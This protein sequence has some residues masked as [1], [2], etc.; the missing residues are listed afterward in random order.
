MFTDRAH[1]EVRAGAGGNGCLSFRREAHVPKGG[2]DGGDG[3]RGGDV[4]LRCDDSLR[5]LQSFR[6]RAHFRAE[7]GGHG[8]GSQRHGADGETLV[9]AVPPGT[10]VRRWDGTRYDLVR[11]GQEVTIARGGAGGRGNT[12]FKSSVRQTPRLAERGLPGEEGR[13]DLHL[14]LLADVGLV[15]LPNA[16]KSSLLARLTRAH[17]KVAAYPFTTLEPVLGTLD[18]EDRQLVI[19]D[20]PGLIEGASEGAGLGHDF[21]AHVER[22]RLLVHVLDLA[23][24]DGSNPLENHRVIEHELAE[25]DPRLAELPRILALSKADLVPA[26][27]AEAAAVE[28]GDRLGVPAVVT[29]A[30]TGQGL[31]EL[32]RTLLRRVPVA[33]PVPEAADEDEVAEFQVFHPAAGR[34][35]EVERV[36]DGEFRVTGE[37]VDRLIARH[38]LENEEALAHVEHRLRRM[39]VI[40]ALEARGFE[41][42][43]DVELGGV[44][45]ELDPG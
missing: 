4:V 17:P 43:D 9:V 26:D 29:S 40:A 3:G 42:G 19:A 16:G 12:R 8:Q 13:V 39:G 6:R 33:E 28:W 15:G 18:A 44:A 38:D 22:T 25:H 36:G 37:A 30:A 10:Q 11:P 45:F 7:R 35:F 41:P 23:P 20:I 5:D 2:P 31:D 14:K 34:A 24:L 1:L 27:A 21:L 32:R